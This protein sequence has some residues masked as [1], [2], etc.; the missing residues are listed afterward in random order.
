MSKVILKGKKV[1]GGRAA[2]A[3]I[4]CHESISFIGGVDPNTGYVIE[5]GHELEGQNIS[6]KVLV[7]PTG[8]G[9]TGGSYRLYEM[10]YQKTAPVAIV[11]LEREPVVTVGCIMGNI[12]M[13]DRLEKS[14]LEEI[15]NGD[16]V[17]VDA[18][19]E[20]IIITKA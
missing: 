14:P 17:V 5:K 6:G 20:T 18:D 11:L 3:A 10:V 4:V 15:Q 9:S 7:Y 2:G 1:V 16:F 12:P 13:V 19:D 8:K